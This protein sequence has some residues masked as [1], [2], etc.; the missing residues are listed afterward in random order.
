MVTVLLGIVVLVGIGIVSSSTTASLVATI[1]AAVV[2]LLVWL[3]QV[4]RSTPAAP[5][6]DDRQLAAARKA[7][8]G[9]VGKQWE[10]EA[11]RR[12]LVADP[13][14]RVR[15]ATD[16]RRVT[17]RLGADSTG[18][19]G[20]L[21]RAL[22][23]LRMP[24]ILT[25]DEYADYLA[26]M[27]LA[28]GD[29]EHQPRAVVAGVPGC[30]KSTYALLL[31]LG[32]LGRERDGGPVPVLLSLASWDPGRESARE[33][34]TRRITETY[35]LLG[36]AA[37]FGSGAARA[38]VDGGHVLPVLDGL[39]EV[40]APLRAAAIRRLNADF[41]TG[42]LVVTCRFAEYNELVAEDPPLADAAVLSPLAVDPHD[43]VAWLA[44]HCDSAGDL[45]RWEPV[46]A[47]LRAGA[48]TPVGSALSSPLLLTLAGA[49]YAGPD[50]RPG[51]LTDPARYPTA[52]DVR[53]ELLDE[54]VPVVYHAA[55]D[56]GDEEGD[57]RPARIAWDPGRAERWLGF[58]ADQMRGFDKVELLWWRLHRAVPARAFGVAAGVLAAGCYGLSR[59]LPQGLTKGFAIGIAVCV[60]LGLL[61]GRRGLPVSWVSALVTT[62][63]SVA[64]IGWPMVGA[65]AAGLD[66]VEMALGVG[67]CLVRP[68]R[69]AGS[70]GAAAAYGLLVGAL[71]G[72]ACG[73]YAAVTGPDEFAST[74]L[75]I[76][77][78]VTLG[79]TMAGVSARL[80][81]DH[82]DPAAPARTELRLG[83][84]RTWPVPQM[85]SALAVGVLV[86]CAGGL[87]GGL[88]QGD[89]GYGL[90]F[91]ATFGL[92]AGI[93][94]GLVGGF[95]R[96]FNEPVKTIPTASPL[97]TLRSDRLSALVHL[98]AIGAV[99]ALGIGVLGRALFAVTGAA[100]ALPPLGPVTGLRFGL[101]IG[102]VFAACLT[103]WPAFVTAHVTLAVTGKIPW[104]LMSFL[105]D[106]YDLNV[107]RREGAAYQF[108]HSDI[109][110]R[111][112]DRYRTGARRRGSRVTRVR[113]AA[114]ARTSR[115]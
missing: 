85:A 72:A 64:L 10:Q 83:R 33:W 56:A 70:T 46:F 105:Q 107:L 63:V 67:L 69:L 38:L 103:S 3:A 75:G 68:A 35:P 90:A 36:D 7:L 102:G 19:V 9:H 77:L 71:D 95:L 5:R 109:R 60:L 4:L 58:I 99:C 13:P 53:L 80:L 101:C 16:S 104:R 51:G 45:A 48:G 76:W 20:K 92:A 14:L 1:V 82:P 55:D 93:P 11:K 32:L 66:A 59:G 39:D 88:K 24:A 113:Q 110:D 12:S 78:A 40:P 49:V 47:A 27:F 111:L 42:A 65:R 62:A 112:A 96:W 31:T 29:R 43:A 15:W 8:A 2:P 52:E 50:S 89:L 41:P 26:R 94:V 30:G 115:C 114:T 61:R 84:R 17:D 108:R 44:A 23:R 100:A 34:I 21:R 81:I 6:T 91:G 73:I 106:A 97:S 74:A 86:G 22:N 54:Y 18:I 87:V 79:V 37:E 25:R 98:L 28:T 57:D